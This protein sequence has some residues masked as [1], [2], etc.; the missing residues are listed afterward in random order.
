MTSDDKPIPLVSEPLQQLS[1]LSDTVEA[2]IALGRSGAGLPT[3]AAQ[4]FL[5]D[6]A[7]AREAVWSALDVDAIT[8][9]LARQA[10]A[11]QGVRSLAPDRATYLRRPDLGRRLNE[12]DRESL[13]AF[14]GH[15][16]LAIVVSDGLSATAVERNAIPLVLAIRSQL[17]QGT[18]T[19]FPVIVATQARVALS[20]EI[21]ETLGADITLC[22]IGERPGLS[23][24]DSLGAYITYQP[25]C[26]LL[27]SS[28]N[29]ISN[30]RNGGLS[31]PEA[32]AQILSLI[33]AMRSQKRSG[34]D[35]V[36]PERATL[37]K[38]IA[39]AALSARET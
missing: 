13:S 31:I 36:I 28:R 33:A 30:I 32:A 4:K 23:A 11:S 12:A 19:L 14:N 22:L 7:H 1:A 29:C 38:D 20:D 5:L 9:E 37:A 34:V 16:R 3:R 10:I 8:E 15:G 35:L 18:D 17:P 2:R 27:D 24:A 26:G 21:G 25:R 6:H 39:P